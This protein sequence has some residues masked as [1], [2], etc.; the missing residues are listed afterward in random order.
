M[1]ARSG[2]NFLNQNV[3]LYSTFFSP[4]SMKTPGVTC[5]VSYG[6]LDIPVPQ[7]V[8]YEPSINPFISKGVA[9]GM[10]HAY[11]DVALSLIRLTALPHE[12]CKKIVAC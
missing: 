5:G 8:L 2:L 12:V 1:K 7:I 9:A 6:V 4:Y 3:R 10:S 11:E